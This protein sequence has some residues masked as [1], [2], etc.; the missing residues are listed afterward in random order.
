[1]ATSQL[2]IAAIDSFQG[3][4][5]RWPDRSCLELTRRYAKLAQGIDISKC[6][7]EELP[8]DEALTL[9]RKRHKRVAQAYDGFLK[10]YFK[11]LK[12]TVKHEEGDIVIVSS[13]TPILARNGCVFDCSEGRDLL[14]L[15]GGYSYYHWTQHG[16][17]IIADVPFDVVAVY[18]L[19]A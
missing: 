8:E 15:Y 12:K 9:V 13:D 18:R 6:E 14:T 2:T 3:Y 5:Y 1:M 16:L 11:R 7:Y 17:S 19:K 4:A 10:P